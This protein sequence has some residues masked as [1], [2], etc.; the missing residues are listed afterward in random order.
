M[1]YLLSETEKRLVRSFAGPPGIEDATRTQATRDRA[2]ETDYPIHGAL[3]IALPRAFRLSG[4]DSVWDDLLNDT[5]GNDDTQVDQLP[6]LYMEDPKKVAE[7]LT[8]SIL[9]AKTNGK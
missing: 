1:W 7:T 9:E 2:V 5:Q 6:G 8:R 4:L 3:R